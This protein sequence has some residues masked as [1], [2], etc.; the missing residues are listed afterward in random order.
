M[1]SGAGGA[2]VSIPALSVTPSGS[3]GRGVY[4]FEEGMWW[5]AS[6]RNRSARSN[7]Q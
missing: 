1:N 5:T 3:L 7:T 2:S 6:G 4:G